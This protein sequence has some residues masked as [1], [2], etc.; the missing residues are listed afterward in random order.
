MA[1]PVVPAYSIGRTRAWADTGATWERGLGQER[2]LK[3]H[4][5]KAVPSRLLQQHRESRGSVALIVKSIL[6]AGTSEVYAKPYIDT[7]PNPHPAPAARR[8]A[9]S[10]NA[11]NSPGL[12]DYIS[13]QLFSARSA[14]RLSSWSQLLKVA[15]RV[16]SSNNSLCTTLGTADTMVLEP[17]P[18]R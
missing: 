12:P 9:S 15:A 1:P 6:I 10:K 16:G 13:T 8:V 2:Q 3:E 7:P 14:I 5:L 18:E 17:S 4:T 11:S